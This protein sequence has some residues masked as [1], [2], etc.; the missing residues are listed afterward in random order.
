MDSEDEDGEAELLVDV[1]V[2]ELVGLSGDM[3]L[4]ERAW[5]G[6]ECC[7]LGGDVET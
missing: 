5:V 4:T 3:E 1:C 7:V 2:E 6:D